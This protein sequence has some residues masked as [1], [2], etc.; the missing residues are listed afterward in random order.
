MISLMT[1]YALG[2]RPE[3]LY[4]FHRTS[5]LLHVLNTGLVFLLLF[6]LFR[7]LP[8]A[9]MVALLFGLHPLT[10]EPMAWVG[11]RKTLLATLFGLASVIA[12]VRST[13]ARPK[14]WLG[15]SLGAFALALLAKPT[16][17]PLPLMLLV[18]DRWPL[19]RPAREALAGK[20]PYLAMATASAV[21]TLV[22]HNRTAGLGAV[23][24]AALHERILLVGYRLA[25]YLGKIAW[26]ADLSPVYPAPHPVTLT[27]PAVLTGCLVTVI[28]VAGLV[29]SWRRTPAF[30]VAFAVLF[31]GLLPT[32]GLVDYSWI[33]ASDK[34][35]YFPAVGLLILAGW[36]VATGWRRGP[37]FRRILVAASVLVFAAEAFATR[38]YLRRWIDTETLCHYILE[39][40]PDTAQVRVN[41][42]RAYADAGRIRDAEAAYRQALESKPGY[43]LALNNLGALLVAEGR[44]EE[45]IDYLEQAL[46][47]DPLSAE[48]HNNL[49]VALLAAGDREVARQHAEQAL[50]LRPGYPRPLYNMGRLALADGDLDE[51][52]TWYRK[53][54]LAQAEYPA[55][56]R[57]LAKAY[58]ELGRLEEAAAS[59]RRLVALDPGDGA[60]Y[61]DL[62]IV[63]AMLGQPRPALEAFEHAL[64]VDPRQ[65]AALNGLAWILATHPEPAMR[66]PARAAALAKIAAETTGFRRPEVLDTLAAAQ[67]AGGDF[68]TA[69]QTLSRALDLVPAHPPHQATR[70]AMRDRLARYQAGRPWTD[71][72]K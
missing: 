69:A 48:A 20:V 27:N 40:A 57:E 31:L 7:S 64:A 39:R 59:L 21:I 30:A 67:A 32:L 36:G 51:A 65:P 28:A 50:H 9:A 33:I 60:A 24:V 6:T 53:A 12:Y 16:V 5:L 44:R 61:T 25:F 47:A 49:G 22:S 46:A 17:V 3:N 14:T 45:G 13:Q 29:V 4:V 38:G 1:D 2:G 41:L 10:V 62:G 42:G 18:L 43:A 55:A 66:D 71:D 15:V 72:A 35:L 63:L 8:A 34:Y 26:P 56:H 11:E 68:N 70:E 23:E 54:I 19:R 52:V 37:A 58:R